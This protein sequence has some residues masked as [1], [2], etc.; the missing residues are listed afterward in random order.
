MGTWASLHTTKL[1]LLVQLQLCSASTVFATVLDGAGSWGWAVWLRCTWINSPHR[2]FT[3]LACG[4]G[5]PELSKSYTDM[6][7]KLFTFTFTSVATIPGSISGLGLPHIEH[8]T[9]TCRGGQV[10]N[11]NRRRQ[12][13]SIILVS[14]HLEHVT[15]RGKTNQGGSG[16]PVEGQ[17]DST[18]SSHAA[19]AQLWGR[20]GMLARMFDVQRCFTPQKLLHGVIL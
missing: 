7:S 12:Q 10:P 9:P 19:S 13:L 11:S 5:S 17:A 2:W 20:G 8:S 16:S 15:T 1:Q 3:P 18:W 4:P 6:A 14:L